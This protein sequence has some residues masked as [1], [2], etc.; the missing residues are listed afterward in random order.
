MIKKKIL[1]LGSFA[2]GKT[3]LVK[4][5]VYSIFSEK[6]HTTIGVKVDQKDIRIGGEDIRLII[7]DI[8]GDDDYQKIHPSYF[9]GTSGYLLVFDCTRK[10]TLTKALELIA[11][12]R[13][14]IGP[15]P[16]VYVMNKIDLTGE[17]DITEEDLKTNIP[18]GMD[19]VRTSAKTGEGVEEAFQVLAR[20]LAV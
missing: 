6:Y 16:Y 10:D 19:L 11:F 2:V 15:V 14:S 3:S 1:L 20:K 13:R 5:Y 17:Y 12:V 4:R 7:W 9:T 8:H 18:S